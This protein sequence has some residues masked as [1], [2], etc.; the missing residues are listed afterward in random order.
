MSHP[1]LIGRLNILECEGQHVLQAVM[2]KQACGKIEGGGT[3]QQPLRI[4]LA[5]DLLAALKLGLA[6]AND[7]MI[8]AV[9]FGCRATEKVSRERIKTLEKMI[10]KVEKS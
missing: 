9:Q 6:S 10:A 8:L 2:E 7:A 4:E 3:C 1:T 5:P